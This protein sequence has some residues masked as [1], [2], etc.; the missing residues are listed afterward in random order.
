MK[1]FLLGKETTMNISL[2]D[3]QLISGAVIVIVIITASLRG[4]KQGFYVKNYPA[5]GIALVTFVALAVWIIS[6][7]H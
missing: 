2:E 7:F 5:M 6:L 1:Y 3:Y 4:E